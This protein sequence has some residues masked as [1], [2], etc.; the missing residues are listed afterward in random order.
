MTMF[1]DKKLADNDCFGREWLLK[2]LITRVSKPAWAVLLVGDPGIG[3][4]TFAAHLIKCSEAKDPPLSVL[5]FWACVVDDKKTLSALN[6]VRCMVAMLQRVPG[7]KPNPEPIDEQDLVSAMVDA[8]L[9][10]LSECRLTGVHCLLVDGLDESLLTSDGQVSSL[11]L[12]LLIAVT[13][14]DCCAAQ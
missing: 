13:D 1:F 14:Y 8:V 9:R 3:K 2:D 7:F 11:L 4:T 12:L 6:F 10:P 5:A